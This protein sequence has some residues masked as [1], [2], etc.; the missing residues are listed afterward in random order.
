MTEAADR[1]PEC[2]HRA[3]ERL[4]SPRGALKVSIRLAF[5]S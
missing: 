1:F 5:G 3:G 2:L 4:Q